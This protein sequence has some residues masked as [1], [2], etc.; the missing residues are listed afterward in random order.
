MAEKKQ[1]MDIHESAEYEASRVIHNMKN[2]IP[3]N[4]LRIHNISKYYKIQ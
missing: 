3:C 4:G 1:A 2:G